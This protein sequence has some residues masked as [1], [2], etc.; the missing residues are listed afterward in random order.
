MFNQLSVYKFSHFEDTYE[1]EG[2]RSTNALKNGIV[3][4][5]FKLKI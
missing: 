2:K 4:S 5:Q 1:K 3:V